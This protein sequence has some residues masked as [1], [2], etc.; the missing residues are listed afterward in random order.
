MM[1]N[2]FSLLAL[3]LILTNSHVYMHVFVCD[4][5]YSR[6]NII[7]NLNMAENRLSSSMDLADAR[8]C[9]IS[10]LAVLQSSTGWY[11]EVIFDAYAARDN[12]SPR[13]T[14]ADGVR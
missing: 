3:S 4:V 5:N 11:I 1:S 12:G 14:V 13:T 6:Y 8:D 10:D 7:G 2:K 9:L